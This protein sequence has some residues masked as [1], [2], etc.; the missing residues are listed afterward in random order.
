[1]F[2]EKGEPIKVLIGIR[3][4]GFAAMRAG[5]NPPI[6][7][8]RLPDGVLGWNHRY[9]AARHAAVEV[10]YRLRLH[11]QVGRPKL[12][13]SEDRFEAFPHPFNNWIVWDRQED[14]FAEVGEYILTCVPQSR[15]EALCFLLN[16]LFAKQAA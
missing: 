13:D 4:K 12:A 8:S 9:A 3:V 5:R 7:N 2:A 14:D 1:M 11:L 10:H 6:G 15:A 16:K